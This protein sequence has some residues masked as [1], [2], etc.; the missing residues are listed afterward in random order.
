MPIQQMLLGAGKVP[1]PE[2]QYWYNVPQD[3]HVQAAST[4]HNINVPPNF[5][6]GWDI[7]ANSF[8]AKTLYMSG[9]SGH[10]WQLS[11]L[12][13]GMQCQGTQSSSYD[14]T[15]LVIA[16]GST[17]G[18]VVYR[19]QQSYTAHYDASG[20]GSYFNYP[21]DQND[22]TGEDFCPLLNCNQQYVVGWMFQSV[23]GFND[24]HRFTALNGS[25]SN[26]LY[27]FNRADGDSINL[28]LQTTTFGSGGYL[29]TDTCNDGAPSSPYCAT[30]LRG[31][32]PGFGFRLYG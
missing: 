12:G 6:C 13:F 3:T 7:H 5:D 20:Q 15:L 16:G 27:N 31:I 24:N 28:Y 11:H 18:T 10:K 26:H 4:T 22:A 32:I 1:M 25:T 21:L 30:A 14:M 23:V 19:S 17:A 9:G 29:N 8:E 2:V